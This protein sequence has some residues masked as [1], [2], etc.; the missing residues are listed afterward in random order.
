MTQEA[1][2]VSVRRGLTSFQSAEGAPRFLS[3]VIIELGLADAAAVDQALQT[4]RGSG[5][6]VGTVLVRTGTL[7]EDQLATALAARHGLDHVDLG[8]FDVDP[9]AAN[10]LPRAAAERYRA[11]PVAFQPDGSLLV[12]LADPSDSLAVSDIAFM[13]KLD[14]RPAAGAA[15]LISE[16]V[17][18]LPLPIP[19][20]WEQTSP[21]A[22][23]ADSQA[24]PEEGLRGELE[25][26]RGELEARR[27]EL[28]SARA[29]LSARTSELEQSRSEATDR[30]ARAEEA[31][32]R[33]G[34]AEG[35][36]QQAEGRAHEAEQRSAE[37]RE[38]IAAMRQEFELEREAHA[39][40]ERELRRRLEAVDELRAR[41]RQLS[42]HF[43]AGARELA[44]AADG[45]H[46]NTD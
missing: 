40:S 38:M 7:T 35:R 8:E 39:A 36:V 2:D 14:V 18:K 4:A 34:E 12:A 24:E 43:A 41:L 9:S 22:A 33:A 23:P 45:P 42:E 5:E 11:V 30:Q 19:E 1:T 29:E 20:D 17:E 10:L 27:G 37:T 28:E 3:D 13:T 44:D 15:H 16:L 46:S 21:Y 32:R 25:R 26:L 31:E 6:M